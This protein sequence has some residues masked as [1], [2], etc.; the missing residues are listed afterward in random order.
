MPT[1]DRVELL[2]DADSPALMIR[3]FG[4]KPLVLSP[5]ESAVINYSDRRTLHVTW[6]RDGEP[7]ADNTERKAS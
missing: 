4:V 7:P 2:R 1:S 6:D 3:A 5:G